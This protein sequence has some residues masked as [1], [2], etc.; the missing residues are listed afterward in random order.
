MAHLSLGC[1]C[2]FNEAWLE[3]FGEAWLIRSMQV[4]VA[5]VVRV[6]QVADVGRGEER[7]V[8]IDE[9]G[10]ESIEEASLSLGGCCCCWIV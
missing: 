6:G 8:R 10:F 2:L 3:L 7:L 5:D 1:C 4:R 9:A